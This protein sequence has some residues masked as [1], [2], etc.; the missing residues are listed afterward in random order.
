VADDAIH[1]EP[2]AGSLPAPPRLGTLFRPVDVLGR[3]VVRSFG[4]AKAQIALALI[5]LGVAIGR[6]GVASPGVR[7]LVRS[8]VYR[9]GWR[10]L[11]MTTFLALALGLVIIA[12]TIALLTQVGIQ[13]Y[14]G[15]V[16]VSVVV[17]ELGPLAVALLVLAQVGT[18]VVIELGTARALGEV[19]ALEAQGIDPIHHLVV[20][21]VVGLALS[22]FSLTVYFIL[23]ALAGGYVFAFLQDVPLLPAEYFRQIAE[24]LT[25]EDFVWLGLKTLG[26]GG[27]IATSACFHGLAQPMRLEDISRATTRAVVQSVVG[28]VLLDAVF[29]GVYLVR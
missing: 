4:A 15:V 14:V 2:N 13:G 12:Q 24:A 23:A 1:I 7:P 29:I 27:L 19:E 25:A 8:Q 26:F 11:P 17:R 21:R 22:V 16:M 10:L 28:C 9:A 5:S 3:V 20:P 6:S 18:A